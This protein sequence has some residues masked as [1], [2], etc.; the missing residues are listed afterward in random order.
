MNV[1]EVQAEKSN[2][3]FSFEGKSGDL[4]LIILKNI[5]LT[6]LTFGIYFPY[7]KTNTRKYFWNHLK[8]DGQYFD[9]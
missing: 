1:V 4:I 9:Y 6:L 5:L 7:A 2:S 3:E 8:F